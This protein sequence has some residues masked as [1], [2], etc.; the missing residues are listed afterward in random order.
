MAGVRRRGRQGAGVNGVRAVDEYLVELGSALQV[1][2]TLGQ[3]FVTAG[4]EATAVVA[5]FILLGPALGL[6]RR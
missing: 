1:H 2:A 5:C 4:I 3:A 6:W